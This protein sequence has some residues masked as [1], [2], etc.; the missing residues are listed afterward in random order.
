MH[1]EDAGRRLTPRLW[2]TDWL[3]LRRLGMVIARELAIARGGAAG[4]TLVDFGCGSM[5]YRAVVEGMGLFYAGA[6]FGSPTLPIGDDGTLPMADASADVVL[7]VQV[8]EHVRDLDRYLGEAARVLR[9]NGTLILSTH[10]AWLYHP[11]PE[12]HRRWTRT[13]LVLDIEARGFAVQSVEP[14]VGP[15]ATTTLIRLAGFAFVLRR[16]PI[17]GRALAGGL[18]MVMNLRSWLED[19][20]TPAAIRRDNACIY[21]VRCTRA[22]A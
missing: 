21:V 3:M 2:D 5:P 12:D 7:S 17:A 13:G 18:A 20:V 9:D 16:L 14:L 1:G 11:H 4:G 10:G 19:R 8:L 6:D 22:P 15:L